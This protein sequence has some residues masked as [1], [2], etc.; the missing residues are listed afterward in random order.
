MGA[1]PAL[2]PSGEIKYEVQEI[3]QH[4]DRADNERWYEVRWDDGRISS[5]PERD[6]Y[7]CWERV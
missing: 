5:I 4:F 6:S 2:M 3:L 7:N 1:P